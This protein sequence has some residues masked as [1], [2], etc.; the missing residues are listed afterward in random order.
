MLFGVLVFRIWLILLFCLVVVVGGFVESFLGVK[1]SIV[2]L[3]VF[4]DGTGLIRYM[5]IIFVC[6]LSFICK[7]LWLDF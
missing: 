3:R 1:V 5:N 6:I 4:I 2:V 7:D